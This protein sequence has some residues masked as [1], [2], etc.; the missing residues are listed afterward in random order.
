MYTLEHYIYAGQ[1]LIINLLIKARLQI[2]KHEL[3]SNP[4]PAE[5]F[6]TSQV[7]Q[8]KSCMKMKYTYTWES[9]GTS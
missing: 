1:M 2:C 3:K 5:N 9:S 7:C 4:E 8:R 6:I